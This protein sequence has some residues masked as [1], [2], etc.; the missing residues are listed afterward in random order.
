M[1]LRRIRVRG[2][3]FPEDVMKWINF[4]MYEANSEP[5]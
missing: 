1:S 3:M 5:K 2:G 4:W